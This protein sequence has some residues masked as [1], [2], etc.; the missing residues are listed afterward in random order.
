MAAAL[1]QEQ[2]TQVH[3]PDPQQ[4]GPFSD[5]VRQYNEDGYVVLRNVLDPELMAEMSDHM[6]FLQRQYPELPPEHFHHPVSSQRPT[7][8]SECVVQVM[9]NDPFWV[10]C[11]SDSRLLDVA[12]GFLGK[13][14][15]LALFSSHYFCKMPGTGNGTGCCCASALAAG[16]QLYLRAVSSCTVSSCPFKLPLHRHARTVAPRR[17]LLAHQADDRHHVLACCRSVGRR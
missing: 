2:N 15:G 1:R 13:P 9:R 6:S 12:D 5:A 4:A 8:R 3:T 16:H 17:Q 11:V 10:R 14:D 7:R